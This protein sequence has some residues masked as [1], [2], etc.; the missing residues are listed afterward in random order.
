MNTMEDPSDYMLNPQGYSSQYSIT[1][2]QQITQ[3]QEGNAI[4]QSPSAVPIR[5]RESFKTPTR[6]IVNLTLMSMIEMLFIIGFGVTLIY[7]YKSKDENWRRHHFSIS[8]FFL[9]ALIIGA[10]QLYNESSNVVQLRNI[11]NKLDQILSTM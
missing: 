5:R 4:V 6:S 10:M 8:M 3:P 2:E 11:S 1:E 7:S 9:A